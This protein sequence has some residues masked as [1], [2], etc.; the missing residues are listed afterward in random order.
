MNYVP[1]SKWNLNLN[2]YYYTAQT[3]SH[4]SNTL[5]NDG[6]RG[7]DHIKGKVIINANISYELIQKLHLNLNAK[8][9]LN[10][11]SREFFRTDEAPFM[12]LGGVS[13]EF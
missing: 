10:N 13:Y 3:Y 2:S 1:N 11:S 7:I 8:N 6:V 5:F 12:L 9:L 4:L